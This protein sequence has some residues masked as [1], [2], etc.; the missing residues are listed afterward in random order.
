MSL[1]APADSLAELSWAPRSAEAAESLRGSSYSPGGLA[2]VAEGEGAKGAGQ[3][4]DRPSFASSRLF[5]ESS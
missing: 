2:G 5:A 4:A 3:P 1:G